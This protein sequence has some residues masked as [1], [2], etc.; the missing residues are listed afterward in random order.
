MLI[1]YR[2]IITIRY[3]TNTIPFRRYV[4]ERVNKAMKL[5]R[6]VRGLANTK[7]GL[8]AKGLCK[9]V[10]TYVILTALYGNEAWYR[11]RT[12][13]ARNKA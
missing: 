13:L 10:V 5:A 12:K 9:A 2:I 3:V 11:G 1:C 6:H 4:E 7:Y 8:L